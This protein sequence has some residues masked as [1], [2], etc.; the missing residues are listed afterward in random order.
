MFKLKRLGLFPSLLTS[1]QVLGAEKLLPRA[2]KS[3][4]V[5][6]LYYRAL[7]EFHGQKFKEA[8]ERF[9]DTWNLL[10]LQDWSHRR[11]VA[12]YIIAIALCHGMCP[13]NDF[14]IKYKLDEDLK[15]ISNSILSGNSFIFTQELNNRA[16]S[17]HNNL[18]IYVF[19]LLNAQP[20]IHLNLVKRTW[21][22]AGKTKIIT[23]EQIRKVAECMKLIEISKDE[24]EC[25]LINLI[26]KVTALKLVFVFVYLC[27]GMDKRSFRTRF[28]VFSFEPGGTVSN[29]FKIKNS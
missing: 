24:L 23:F 26:G 21:K 12:I 27:L 4:S 7:Y 1:V 11:R 28:A 22:L 17:L 9:K 14:L 6:F 16:N 10:H 13:S 15:T 8:W 3:D 29:N 25:I 18:N 5:Q 20:A 19:L 2:R